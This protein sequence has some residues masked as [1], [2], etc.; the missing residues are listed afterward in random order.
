[1][2]AHVVGGS[3]A[4]GGVARRAIVSVALCGGDRDVPGT[5]AL[6]RARRRSAASRCTRASPASLGAA[7]G[8]VESDV[9]PERSSFASTIGFAYGSRSDDRVARGVM[10]R[11]G[12]GDLSRRCPRV[13][14]SRAE[15]ERDLRGDAAER[16]RDIVLLARDDRR[17][18]SCRSTS[19]LPAPFAA[20]VELSRERDRARRDVSVEVA[21]RRA[22]RGLAVAG[23]A[24]GDR[25]RAGRDVARAPRGARWSSRPG[26]RSR[27]PPTLGPSWGRRAEPGAACGRQRSA[28][29]AASAAARGEGRRREAKR[30]HGTRP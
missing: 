5:L 16:D 9:A 7:T 30:E 6:K 20:V 24:D 3:V 22:V 26:S 1:M 17:R 4:G 15:R 10:R 18:S 14:R 25:L 21:R 27:S 28:T 2:R 11:H 12:D 13:T 29:A 19:R 23:E 8:V